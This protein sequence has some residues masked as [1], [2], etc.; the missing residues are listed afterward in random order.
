MNDDTDEEY[1]AMPKNAVE[2]VQDA[3]AT[4]LEQDGITV[5]RGSQSHGLPFAVIHDTS[6]SDETLQLRAENEQ[7]RTLV[8]SSL[9]LMLDMRLD[10]IGEFGVWHQAQAFTVIREQAKTLGIEVQE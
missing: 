8:S 9:L 10:L 5:Y 1:R 4:L 7:L 2:Q 3:V 6:D